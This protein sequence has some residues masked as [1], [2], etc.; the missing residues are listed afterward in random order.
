MNTIR[1]M[2]TSCCAEAISSNSTEGDEDLLDCL[3]QRA[4]GG[5]NGDRKAAH[6]SRRVVLGRNVSRVWGD[7]CTLPRRQRETGRSAGDDDLRKWSS[8]LCADRELAALRVGR[9]KFSV[10]AEKR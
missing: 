4:R 6:S 8:L 3:G 5:S 1:I 7:G 2:T 10:R 9:S